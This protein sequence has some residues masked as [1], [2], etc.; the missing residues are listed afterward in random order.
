MIKPLLLL[1]A[2]SLCAVPV[3]AQPSLSVSG[4]TSFTILAGTPVDM[5][6]LVLTPAADFLITA[7]AQLDLNTTLAHTAAGTH[8]LRVY[9]WSS[10]LNIFRGEIGFYYNDAELNG[11][12]KTSL[13]LQLHN[14]VS[15]TPFTT[16]LI[17]NT[18]SNLV[19]TTVNNYALDE[20]TLTDEL[21]L[22]PLVWG[23][24][25]AYRAQDK[26]YVK[27]KAGAV[28]KEDRFIVERSNDG[29]DWH[30][31]AAPVQSHGEP[32]DGF[33]TLEDTRAPA[34]KTFYRVRLVYADGTTGSWSRMVMIP[35]AH[36][37]QVTVYPNPVEDRLTIQSS[38][39]G[40]RQIN[41]Y[42]AT[43]RSVYSASTGNIAF[44]SLAATAF[45]PG[46]YWLQLVLA[47]NTITSFPI[48]KK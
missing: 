11:L 15:W 23:P 3:T 33:Y 12:A 19:R 31:V 32:Y 28:K 43:G 47:D 16:G 34:G 20:L 4:S 35:A 38:L 10:T 39:I 8:V 25:I 36:M 45:P 41:L 48:I 37:A 14:G 2:G 27:W 22:L 26:A 40:I 6:G 30:P 18:G 42:N 13:V 24:V 7:P 5:N 29:T 44:Y 17:R 1:A 9:K 46:Y 21:T